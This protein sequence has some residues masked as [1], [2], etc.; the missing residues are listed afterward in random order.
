MIENKVDTEV[1]LRF[2]CGEAYS[3]VGDYKPMPHYMTKSVWLRSMSVRFFIETII[4]F[5]I[6]VVYQYEI[7]LFNRDLHLSIEELAHYRALE[8]EI[9]AR[10]GYVAD[11]IS[12][13]AEGGGKHSHRRY[14]FDAEEEDGEER[15]DIEEEE[16]INYSAMSMEELIED[17]HHVHD[18]L[19]EEF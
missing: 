3:E 15:E 5:A 10:G 1:R 9:E 16:T 18:I 11:S 8:K 19:L 12:S 17:K 14:L 4:F 7:S 13:H 6:V 2:K